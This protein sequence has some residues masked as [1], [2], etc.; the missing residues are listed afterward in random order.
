[1]SHSDRI[2]PG[3][4]F[5]HKA[6][7]NTIRRGPARAVRVAPCPGR[8]NDPRDAAAG[9]AGARMALRSS[10]PEECPVARN[11]ADTGSPGS[12]RFANA[13]GRNSR[14]LDRR[15]EETTRRC[16]AL[17]TDYRCACL[18]ARPLACSSA[19]VEP[20]L[21]RT[22][23]NTGSSLG[24]LATCRTMTPHFLVLP[25]YAGSSSAQISGYREVQRSAARLRNTMK[26]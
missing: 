8:A 3:K 6:K 25:F 1:M 20:L 12:T 17:S 15:L 23:E 22:V 14:A 16:R 10:T 13:Q 11:V 24:H 26:V 7:N 9:T 21:D 2:N 5:R 19:P 4:P 18:T